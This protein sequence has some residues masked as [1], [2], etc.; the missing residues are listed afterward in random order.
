MRDSTIV[1]DEFSEVDQAWVSGVVN[2]HIL[3]SKI[4]VTRPCAMH[5][6]EDPPNEESVDSC[7]A[8][9][10]VCGE[11]TCLPKSDREIYPFV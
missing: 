2:D 4:S 3:G 10:T 8:S 7:V 6:E 9:L 5:M 11:T 1:Q